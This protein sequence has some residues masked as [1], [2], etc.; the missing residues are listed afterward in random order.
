MPKRL[1]AKITPN[2][3][4]SNAGANLFRPPNFLSKKLVNNNIE[5]QFICSKI[6][7][8]LLN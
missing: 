8:N 4:I 5:I 7:D 2:K 6:Y 1:F 3:I